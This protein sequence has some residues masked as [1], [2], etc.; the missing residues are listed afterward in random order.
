MKIPIPNKF[1]SKLLYERRW[2][3]FIFI[4]L[5]ILTNVESQPEGTVEI[6]LDNC[7]SEDDIAYYTVTVTNTGVSM[8]NSGVRVVVTDENG[9]TVCDT[10]TQTPLMSPGESW[11]FS[12]SCGPFSTMGTKTF[13]V[14]LYTGRVCTGRILDQDIIACY[15]VPTLGEILFSIFLI[16]LVGISLYWWK[17]K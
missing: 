8:M 2:K 4:I 10:C 3:I 17:I 14:T 6:S 15:Y 16:S 9:A 5:V 1:K 7:G 13:T 11:S 12:D